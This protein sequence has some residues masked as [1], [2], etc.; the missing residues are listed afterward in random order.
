MVS[1]Q[2]VIREFMWNSKL[3][4]AIIVV[5]VVCLILLVFYVNQPEILDSNK[6]KEGKENFTNM[7]SAQPMVYRQQLLN[8]P[9]ECKPYMGCEWPNARDKCQVSWRDCPAYRKCEQGMCLPKSS[10]S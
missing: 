5:F 2:Q 10:E 9:Y 3:Y 1:F 7:L 4:I 8:A 6:P